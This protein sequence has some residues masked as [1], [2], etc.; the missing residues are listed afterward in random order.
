MAII[1]HGGFDGYSLSLHACDNNK[2]E[3]VLKAFM[4]AVGTYG[5]PSRVRAD[6]GG[7]NA[8]VS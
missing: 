5:L 3:S 6:Y 8:L 7:E 1:V 2:S 4:G